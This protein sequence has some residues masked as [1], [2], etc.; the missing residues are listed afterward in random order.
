[1]CR[2]LRKKEKITLLFPKLTPTTATDPSPYPE[3]NTQPN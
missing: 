1:V 2:E 3:K